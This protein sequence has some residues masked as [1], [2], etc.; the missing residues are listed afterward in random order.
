MAR[1]DTERELLRAVAS[2][3]P[4][5]AER[6]RGQVE[7]LA[8]LTSVQNER[9]K[10]NTDAVAQNTSSRS[11]SSASTAANLSRSILNTIGGGLLLSPLVSGLTRLFRRSPQD[12]AEPPV[13]SVRAKPFAFEAAWSPGSAPAPLDFDQ[14]GRPRATD[15]RRSDAGS[16]A[17]ARQ[18]AS[19]GTATGHSE[20]IQT[21]V[22]I[23]IQA[24]DS[25]SI[26][27]RSDEI[28]RALREAMLHSHPVNDVIHED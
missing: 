12:Q 22:T 15:A 20:P 23:Q 6:L 17:R 2:S 4:Q 28:A 19:D 25:R 24:L 21:N 27:D 3:F 1:T 9:L 11:G 16:S 5:S 8:A 10:E 13:P 14:Y 18:V 7:V 26:L